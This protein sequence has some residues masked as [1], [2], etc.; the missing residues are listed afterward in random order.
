MEQIASLKENNAP[1]YVIDELRRRFAF[2]FD[3]MRM[4]EYYFEQLEGGAKEISG[5]LKDAVIEKYGSVDDFLS[6]IKEVGGSRGIGWIVVS[7]DDKENQIHTTFVADH[8]LGHLSG[9]R[10]LCA[11]DMWEHAFMVDYT[12]AEK[13]NYLDIVLKNINWEVVGERF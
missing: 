2:E 6:H 3:G 5:D 10:V 4:H 7:Y 9:T 11:I 12:P 13:G 8:E 1:Q